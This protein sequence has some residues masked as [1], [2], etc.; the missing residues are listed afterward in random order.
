MKRKN[1]NR[2]QLK[3]GDIKFL[4]GGSTKVEVI[5]NLE[6]DKPL[7][8]ILEATV[9]SKFTVGLLYNINRRCLYPYQGRERTVN[10][11]LMQLPHVPFKKLE[12]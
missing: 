6:G 10:S 5:D 3:K 11:P 12:I 1:H 4:S 7:V 2:T 9:E 8:F